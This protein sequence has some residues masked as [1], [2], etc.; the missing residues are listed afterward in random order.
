MGVTLAGYNTYKSLMQS[1]KYVSFHI[2]R[3]VF[4]GFALVHPPNVI[5]D[6]SH[7][8]EHTHPGTIASYPL[9]LFPLITFFCIQLRA[10]TYVP[11]ACT[12]THQLCISLCRFYH[13]DM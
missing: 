5:Y 7:E 8:T 6:L 10:F 3:H 13:I 12:V 11:A 1:E 4:A 2:K 9:K